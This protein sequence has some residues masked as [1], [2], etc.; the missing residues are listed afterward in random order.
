MAKSG[1]P[2]GTPCSS[3]AESKPAISAPNLAESKRY[4]IILSSVQHQ[5][6]RFLATYKKRLERNS[7]PHDFFSDETFP[8]NFARFLS[9][10]SLEQLI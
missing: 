2:C 5:L 10:Y 7:P 6:G 3:R 8:T 1:L 4:I 9:E